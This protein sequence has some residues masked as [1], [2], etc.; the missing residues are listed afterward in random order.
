MTSSRGRKRTSITGGR[1]GL[2]REPGHFTHRR[3]RDG[4]RESTDAAVSGQMEW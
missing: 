3:M 2:G 4:A 1:V